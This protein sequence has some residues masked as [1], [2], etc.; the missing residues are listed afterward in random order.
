MKILRVMK[1][2]LPVLIIAAGLTVPSFAG[3]GD[4]PAPCDYK[5]FGLDA[6]K[7]FL[8]L[9]KDTP[10]T[11]WRLWPNRG[12]AA[13]AP[14]PHGPFV[15]TYVNPAAYEAIGK[16]EGMAFGS[17]IVME[18]R[19]AANNLKNLAVRI[20]IKGYNPE[21]GDWYWFEYAPDGTASAEGKAG[22]CI[23]CHAK[24]RANDFVMTAPVK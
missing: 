1:S 23:G 8:Y 9:T 11:R 16:R 7:F 15:A 22:A 17:V 10:Y 21:A 5:A 18:S 12:S 24:V 13:P 3:S 2:L 6:P 19:D 14:E 4:Q 20:K